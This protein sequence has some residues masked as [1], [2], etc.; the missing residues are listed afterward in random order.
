MI[1]LSHRNA[2]SFDFCLHAVHIKFNSAESILFSVKIPVNINIRECI[3]CRDLCG[4]HE[5][6]RCE[7][8]GILRQIL[9]NNHYTFAFVSIS[10]NEIICSRIQK[11]VS[12][13]ITSAGVKSYVH[14]S[15]YF[16]IG[17]NFPAVRDLKSQTDK[18]VC[19][20][21][22]INLAPYKSAGLFAVIVVIAV[23]FFVGLFTVVIIVAVVFFV[24]LFAVIVVIIAVVFF[25]GLF[26]VVIVVVNLL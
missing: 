25:V 19:I 18:I 1:F 4:F 15:L 12:F 24:G 16:V 22:V 21:A 11:S 23:V 17:K 7:S 13:E 26:A 3:F 10:C 9:D 20:Y 5:V 8:A 14:G 6:L 2:V